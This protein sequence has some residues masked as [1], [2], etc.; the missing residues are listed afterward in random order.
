VTSITNAPREYRIQGPVRSLAEAV[1][2][3]PNVVVHRD[4]AEETL[5]FNKAMAERQSRIEAAQQAPA[6]PEKIAGQVIANGEVVAT[7]FESGIAITKNSM[8]MPNDAPPGPEL[9]KARLT[10]IAKAV[11]GSIRQSDFL[12]MEGVGLGEAGQRGAGLEAARRQVEETLQ[13]I[14]WRRE[15]PHS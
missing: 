1:K 6:T 5:A 14:L 4:S 7:V 13:S 11:Q 10:A 12:P 9:A 2:E 8:A 15:Q 3:N